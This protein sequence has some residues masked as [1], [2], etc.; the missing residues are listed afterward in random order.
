MNKQN[1]CTGS[2][3]RKCIQEVAYR[4]LCSVDIET[5]L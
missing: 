5:M 2:V 4:K 1:V 3:Y